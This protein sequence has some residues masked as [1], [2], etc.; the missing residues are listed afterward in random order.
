ML[1]SV[2]DFSISLTILS[3]PLALPF[4]MGLVSFFNSSIVNGLL[5]LELPRSIL[6]N[7]S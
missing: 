1:I 7:S 5:R 3:C 2:L 6:L 4:L